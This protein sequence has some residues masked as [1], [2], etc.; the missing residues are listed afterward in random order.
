MAPIRNDNHESEVT[1]KVSSA[2]T[3]KVDDEVCWLAGYL[4]GT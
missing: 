3:L 2:L 1:G 4:T